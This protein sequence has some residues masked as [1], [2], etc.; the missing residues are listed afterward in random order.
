MASVTLSALSRS[1]HARPLATPIGTELLVPAAARGRGKR[2]VPSITGKRRPYCF[3][4]G[5]RRG[6]SAV[7]AWSVW[8]S[9]HAF[10][11][12]L[13]EL[14]HLLAQSRI[15]YDVAMDAFAIGAQLFTQVVQIT[16]Q[17]IDLA[18]RIAGNSPE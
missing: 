13:A 1:G 8:Q 4:V 17:R 16:D 12:D 3:F 9:F 18:R 11:N 10:G 14:H 15:V 5:S 6:E 2:P 7:S